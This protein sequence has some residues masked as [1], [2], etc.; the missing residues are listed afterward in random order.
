MPT[1]STHGDDRAEPGRG[2]PTLASAVA[3]DSTAAITAVG[4]SAAS[5]TRRSHS[6]AVV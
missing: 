5:D 2:L 1:V 3:A 6:A 4:T